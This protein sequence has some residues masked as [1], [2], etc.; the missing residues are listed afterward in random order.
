MWDSPSFSA[1]MFYSVAILQLRGI[2]YKCVFRIASVIPS[3]SPCSVVFPF[4]LFFVLYFWPL[5]P[6]YTSLLCT[7]GTLFIRDFYWKGR[8]FRAFQSNMF[9]GKDFNYQRTCSIKLD[10]DIS[11]NVSTFLHFCL[12]MARV[13]DKCKRIK[14]WRKEKLIVQLFWGQCLIK[15]HQLAVCWVIFLINIGCNANRVCNVHMWLRW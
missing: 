14:W 4:F 9:R 15:M 6:A 3:V 12:S 13:R 8:L 11:F 2:D 5:F 7:Y 1:P 10:P